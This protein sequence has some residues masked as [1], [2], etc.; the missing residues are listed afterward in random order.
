MFSASLLRNRIEGRA[1]R[2]V[3]QAALLTAK[4]MEEKGDTY[5]METQQ[6]LWFAL[7][8]HSGFVFSLDGL[9]FDV[10]SMLFF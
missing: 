10:F 5:H 9:C 2:V 1:R 8:I 6:F 4:V 7:V 3:N